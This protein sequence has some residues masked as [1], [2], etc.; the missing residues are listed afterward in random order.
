M[1]QL[2]RISRVI[3]SFNERIGRLTYWILPLMILIGVWNVVGRYLGRF[4]GENLSSNGFI[5][6]QWYLFDLV[7]LLG[8]AY[9]LKHNGH[10]RVDVFYK[11]L[12][13]KAQAIANL[14]GTLLFLIPFCIMVIYFSWGAIVNSWTIQEMSPDPGGLPRYPIKSMII[15]SFGLLIL[16][17]ISEAIKNWAIFAGYL[18]PQEED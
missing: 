18:A 2:L 14:I 15:V 16:Q 8:A 1:Q 10:V 17:G 9:T 12:K 3:D 13:P 6:T 5:E 11:S 7:F 4:I